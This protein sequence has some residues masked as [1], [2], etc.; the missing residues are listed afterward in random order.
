MAELLAQSADLPT[1]KMFCEPIPQH[2]S[3]SITKI[4]WETIFIGDSVNPSW[5]HEMANGLS[6]INQCC[7]FAFK[8][9]WKQQ[10]QS[11]KQFSSIFREDTYCTFLSC[12]VTAKLT[13]TN[14]NMYIH[15]DSV[16]LEVMSTGSTQHVTGETKTR[17]ISLSVRNGIQQHFQMTRTAPSKEYHQRLMTLSSEQYASGNR[18]G[19]ECSSAVI[20]I[21]SKT[22]NAV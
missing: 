10:D 5:V 21:R 3:F 13:I 8:Q 1:S 6:E 14:Q 20:I 2:S 19:V 15:M 17:N 11:R 12:L 7:C 18:N 22:G 4:V 9:H 16:I